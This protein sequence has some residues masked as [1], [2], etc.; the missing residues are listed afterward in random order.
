[1]KENIFEQ[2]AEEYDVWYEEHRFLYQSE[3]DRVKRFLP[4]D[5][6]RIIELGVGSG[7]FAVPL[8]IPSGMEPSIA[9]G[10]MAYK[11]GIAIVRG[12]VEFLPVRQSSCQAVLLM[13]VICFL[14]D[15]MVALQEIHRILVP[16]GFLVIGFIR[17][18]EKSGIKE[19]NNRKKGKFLAHARFYTCQEVAML[20]E[21]SGFHLKETDS[22]DE[23]CIIR[24][25]KR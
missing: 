22:R 16:G 25:E 17:R 4:S 20:L 12:R 8:A 7:R 21:S 1:M 14:A 5:T 2:Y 18:D 11:R 24:A 23:I 13:F 19:N 15:P 10:R 9:L 6:S 3:L